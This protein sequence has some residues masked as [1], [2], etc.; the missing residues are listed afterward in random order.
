MTDKYQPNLS[1]K[2]ILAFLAI[3]LL[4]APALYAQTNYAEAIQQGDR[5]N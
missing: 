5:V 3:C 4:S 2:N 1:M